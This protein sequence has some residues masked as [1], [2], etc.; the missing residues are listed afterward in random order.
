MA[1]KNKEGRNYFEVFDKLF[2]QNLRKYIAIERKKLL[3]SDSEIEKEM[4]QF[5]KMRL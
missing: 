3:I 1:K 5:S 4:F 2:K